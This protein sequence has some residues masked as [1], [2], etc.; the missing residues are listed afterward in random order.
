MS[1]TY[2]ATFSCDDVVTEI[3]FTTDATTDKDITAAAWHVFFENS[4]TEHTLRAAI[5]AMSEV[6]IV[7]AKEK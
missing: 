6:A 4:P 3:T 5:M 2:D 7:E 1:K